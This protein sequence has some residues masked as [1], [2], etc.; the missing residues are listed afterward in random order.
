MEKTEQRQLVT[1]IESEL[2]R[3]FPEESR[4]SSAVVDGALLRSSFTRLVA[5]LA[6]GPEPETRLCPH[7]GGRGMKMAT[8]CGC[9]WKS[10][11]QA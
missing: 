2:L 5:L 7:C 8:V 3:L 4:K 1:T 11:P 9:C 6:L 10:T